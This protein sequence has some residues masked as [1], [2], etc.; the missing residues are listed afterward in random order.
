MHGNWKLEIKRASR[1]PVAAKG[2]HSGAQVYTI[3][4]H[5]PF[6]APGSGQSSNSTPLIPESEFPGQKGHV[7]GQLALFSTKDLGFLILVILVLLHN[8]YT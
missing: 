2:P 1:A 4:H 6:Q 7:S 8:V 5:D 3:P